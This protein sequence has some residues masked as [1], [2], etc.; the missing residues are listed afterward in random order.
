MKIL[1]NAY[2]CSPYQ[3]SEPGMGWNFVKC[4][5]GKHELHVITECKYKEEIND[6][7]ANHPNEQQYV[8]F[9]YVKRIRWNW[10][11]KIWPPSYYWTYSKW[12]KDALVCALDLDKEENFD[13]VHQL[14]MIGYREPGLLWKMNKPFVWGP[15]GGFN[16][17]PWKLLYTMG[18]YGMVFYAFRNVINIWQMH[19][20]CKVKQAICR[21]DALMSA[22]KDDYDTIKRLWNKESVLMPEVGLTE[23][24]SCDCVN[25]KDNSKLKLCWSGLHIPRKSLNFLIDALRGLD[26]VELHILGD[27]HKTDEWKRLAQRN[28]LSNVVWYGKL[29][30]N[31]AIEVMNSCDVFVQTSLSDATSTVLLEALSLG[32]PVIALNHLGFA[33]VIDDTCGI[34]IEVDSK[35]QIV[36]DLNTA[37]RMLDEDRNLLNNLSAGAKIRAYDHSWDK[38]ADAICFLYNCAY[39]EYHHTK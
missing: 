1:I 6:Y 21:S 22:T 23:C 5:F 30:R 33:N 27:G 24:V 26:N 18:L 11:R 37:I 20:S 8:S 36:R 2:A 10:L 32:M 7:F 31:N 4:L 29:D 13:I 28:K 9:Y 25:R 38:K 16:I 19:H 14:N 15:I 34:K 17:T 39:N 3:G 35:S 12:H